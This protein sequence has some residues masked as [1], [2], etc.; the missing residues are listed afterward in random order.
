MLRQGVAIT[1]Q[2]AH[3]MKKAVFGV[4]GAVVAAGSISVAAQWGKVPDPSVPR[5]AQGNLR[6][7]APPPRTADGKID[8]S[9]MWL[10]ANSGP[11]TEG[12]GRGR[13]GAAGRGGDT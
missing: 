7:D 10:R 5:D 13:G 2:G 11:P 12:R 6:K 8:F 1:K 9:G 3:E 4:I